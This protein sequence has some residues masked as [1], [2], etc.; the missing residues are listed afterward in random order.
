MIRAVRVLGLDIGSVRIGVA[1]SDPSG[2]VATPLAVLDARRTLVDGDELRAIVEEQHPD[3]IVVGLPVTM[4]GEEGPQARAVREAGEALG[5]MLGL[6]V[7]FFDER[8]TTVQA[9][10]AMRAHGSGARTQRGRVDKVAAALL[11]QAYLDS[12]KKE[13]SDEP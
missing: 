1:V 9:S 6:P 4:S 11:L 5:R 2:T 12:S 3:L 8:L 10:A 7:A 13:G